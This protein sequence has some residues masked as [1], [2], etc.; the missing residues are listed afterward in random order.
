MSTT[1]PTPRRLDGVTFPDG[2]KVSHCKGCG[3]AI[4]W[5]LT[6][7]GK[8]NPF[9]FDLVTGKPTS[10]THWST[11]PEVDQFRRPKVAAAGG[12]R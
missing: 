10:I 12:A 11:C 7:A 2:A 4:C 6:K 3:A 5:G 9:D 1:A 8:K